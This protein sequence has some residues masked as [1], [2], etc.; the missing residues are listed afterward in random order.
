MYGNNETDKLSRAIILCLSHAVFIWY[1]H[2][3]IN[4]PGKS[5]QHGKWNGVTNT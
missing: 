4:L 5:E 2:T 3:E 1:G